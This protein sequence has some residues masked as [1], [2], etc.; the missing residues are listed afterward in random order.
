MKIQKI[1]DKY[2]FYTDGVEH[3]LD[4]GT[5]KRA[6]DKTFTIEITDVEDANK[7]EVIK[8]C[9]CTKVE[10]ISATKEKATWKVTYTECGGKFNK[11]TVIKY[12]K[13]QISKISFSG[14]CQ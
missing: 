13:Q 10:Q 8:T 4:F 9:G 6:E 3:T 5:V 2:N 14:I 11:T 1:S 12:N 7:I